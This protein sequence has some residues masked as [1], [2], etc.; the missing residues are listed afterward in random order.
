[1][2]SELY[3]SFIADYYDESPVV[4]G[5]CRTWLSIATPCASSRSRTGA[6]LRHGAHHDSTVGGGKRITGLDLSERMLERAAKKRAAL[7][8]EAANVFTH[9]GD[10]GTVRSRRKIPAGHYPFPISAPAGSAAAGGF[11]DCVRKHL[12]A[13]RAADP[14]CVPDGCRANARS[15]AHARDAGDGI[16]T[17]DAGSRIT[18]R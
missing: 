15:R 9:T 2:A 14:G 8:V 4:T 7:R 18:E 1:M 17:A 11:L 13:G 6:G 5:G 12:G 3:D 16:Q 10:H